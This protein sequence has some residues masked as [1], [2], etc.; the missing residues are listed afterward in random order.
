MQATTSAS[1]ATSRLRTA[2]ELCLELG[3]SIDE[4]LLSDRRFA[5]LTASCID[6]IAQGG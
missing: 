3:D 2:C 5:S 4:R 6:N 1:L